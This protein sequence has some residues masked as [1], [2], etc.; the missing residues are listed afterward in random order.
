MNSA[1]FRTYVRQSRRE[2]LPDPWKLAYPETVIL[3]QRWRAFGTIELENSLTAIADDMHVGW[4]MVIR[5]N[6]HAQTLYR[7]NSWHYTINL[8]VLVVFFF[9]ST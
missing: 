2:S 5:I 6:R 3:A 7:V 9:V 1:P 4:S 8:S